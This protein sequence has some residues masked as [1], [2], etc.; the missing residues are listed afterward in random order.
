MQKIIQLKIQGIKK[1]K[2]KYMKNLIKIMSTSA[3]ALLVVGCQDSIDKDNPPLD[4]TLG[5]YKTAND[6]AKSSLLTHWAL[7]GNGN[8]EFSGKAPSKESNVTYETGIKGQCATFN[9]G[10][11]M[12]PEIDKLST[13]NSSFTVALW[14]KFKNNQS[15]P[16]M[17]FSLT[18]PE[19]ATPTNLHWA[20]SINIMSET[21]W[22]PDTELKQVIK[23]YLVKNTGTGENGQDTRNNP[24][25]GGVQDNLV[26]GTWTHY[27]IRYDAS[28]E[29]FTV[30][31]NGVKISN[32]DWS[33]EKVLEI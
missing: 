7:D 30:F 26:A 3:L 31:A 5:K 24:G 8:E 6:V 22:Y 27:V 32:P 21:G 1:L 25:T 4:Y 11:L 16:T 29:M 18:K 10:Y 9:V 12:Y 2:P 33:L 23:G 14:A 19:T 20:G 13:I 28:S 15:T 17:L